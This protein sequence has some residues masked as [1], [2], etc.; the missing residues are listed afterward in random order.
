[1]D[2]STEMITQ[3]FQATDSPQ[4]LGGAESACECGG[5]VGQR[6]DIAL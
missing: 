3:F 5:F 4:D 6:W 2:I 1:M